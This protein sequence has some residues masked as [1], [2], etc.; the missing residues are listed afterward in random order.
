MMRDTLMLCSQALA[1][2]RH[3]AGGKAFCRMPPH[4]TPAVVPF[5]RYS[6]NAMS[7]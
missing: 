5:M 4:A 6:Q 7:V 2:T 3:A 1:A